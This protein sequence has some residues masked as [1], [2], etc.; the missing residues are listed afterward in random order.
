MDASPR[1]QL[2]ELR[3]QQLTG[4]PLPDFVSDLRGQHTSWRGIAREVA[5][6]TSG[7]VTPTDVTLINWYGDLVAERAS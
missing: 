2:D 5:A 7:E 4:T 6:A 3:F 1:Q